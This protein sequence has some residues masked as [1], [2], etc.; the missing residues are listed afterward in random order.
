MDPFDGSLISCIPHN[1]TI[2]KPGV[3]CN[4]LLLDNNMDNYNYVDSCHREHGN[5][6]Q[7][8]I[9]L[10]WG[11]EFTC[12]DGAG[13]ATPCLMRTQLIGC[14][15]GDCTASDIALVEAMETRQK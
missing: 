11:S 13:K 1:S 7:K 12:K 3:V 10:V 14:M 6:M 4:A 2:P 5:D 9:D 15:P 8:N